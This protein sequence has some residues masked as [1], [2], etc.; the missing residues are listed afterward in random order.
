M[1]SIDDI[2]IIPSYPPDVRDFLGL[3]PTNPGMQ[4]MAPELLEQQL[5][6]Y[7]RLAGDWPD[8]KSSVGAR[9][10]DLDCQAS[11]GPRLLLGGGPH[12]PAWQ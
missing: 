9:E 4:G 2:I 8:P 1:F 12:H 6:E 11:D 10:H 5:L 3:R 7:A